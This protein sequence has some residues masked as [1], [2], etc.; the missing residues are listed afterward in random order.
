MA[1]LSD[2]VYGALLWLL[3]GP[4]RREYGEAM[5]QTF[6]D[7]C[8]ARGPAVWVRAVPDLV[9]GAARE[10]AGTVRPAFWARSAGLL[11]VALT[12]AL[13][14]YSEVRYPANL[15]RPAYLAGFVLLLAALVGLAAG[16]RA[17]S[18]VAVPF[19]VATAGAWLPGYF[20][21]HLLV[22]AGMATVGALVLA[23]G[24]CAALRTGSP[25]ATLRASLTAGVLAG[26]T[27][28][29]VN[30]ANGLLTMPA[31]RHDPQYLSEFVHSGQRDVAAYI[32]GERIGGGMWGIVFGL[33]AGTL[34]G[35]L[36]LPAG[37][38]RRHA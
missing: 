16:T 14:V 6:A 21:S 2:R 33:V 1:G 23:A 18:P 19:G 13:V 30:V 37:R 17:A 20:D 12:A 4:F 25:A 22:A 28:L 3:P 32:V 15:D 7:L 38:M 29:L 9:G 5:R 26:I 8:A 31:L 35:V 36:S 11:T 24:I 34:L 27:L 10:W